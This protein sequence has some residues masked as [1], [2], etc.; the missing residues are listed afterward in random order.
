[1]YVGDS[2][3]IQLPADYNGERYSIAKMAFC[4]NE[5]FTD[6][7]I[8]DGVEIIGTD[9][10]N[11]CPNLK[12]VTLGKNVTQINSLAFNPGTIVNIQ[13]IESYLKLRFGRSTVEQSTEGYKLYL[14]G[15]P[16]TELIVPDGIETI[17]NMAFWNCDTLTKVVIPDSVTSIGY[18]AFVN[19]SN[20]KYLE[21]GDGVASIG[22]TAFYGCSGLKSVKLGSGLTSKSAIGENAFWGCNSILETINQSS[23]YRSDLPTQLTNSLIIHNGESLI[24]TVED[25]I[26]IKANGVNYLVEYIGEDTDIVLPNDYNGE[27]YAIYK[28]AFANSNITSVVL[29]NGVYEIGVSAFAGCTNLTNIEFSDTLVSIGNNAFYNCTNLS[30]VEIP[31]N[32]K[33]L[34][35]QVFYG[36]SSLKTIYYN[37]TNMDDLASYTSGYMQPFYLEEGEKRTVIIG[38]EVERIPARLFQC[39]DAYIGYTNF[40]TAIIF[41]DGSK[42][43]SIGEYAFAGC[44]WLTSITIPESVTSIGDYVFTST[45]YRLVEII[46]KSSVSITPESDSVVHNG[47]SGIININ[48]YI[49]YNNR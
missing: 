1:M 34:G 47:N 45:C 49:F 7:I 23:I 8:P 24:E 42:C 26:F 48:D 44:S 28:S 18:S 2:T 36:C 9:A 30:S 40:I 35:S 41:E 16:L 31:K 11:L 14:N 15:E 20:L 6:L 39:S 37:A 19:C 25:F 10:F 43:T 22:N 27:T 32:L 5:Y 4:G 3:D 29:G 21:I 12:S 38:N 33:T 17:P 13:S 46:N